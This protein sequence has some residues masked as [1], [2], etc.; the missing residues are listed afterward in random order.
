MKYGPG[1][2]LFGALLGSCV[3]VF[4]VRIIYPAGNTEIVAQAA[5]QEPVYGSMIQPEIVTNHPKC[6]VSD[7]YP[8]KILQW[9]D[10]IAHYADKHNINPDLIAAIIWQESGGKPQAY[11]KSGAVGLMQ[12][13]PRDGIAASFICANGPCFTNRP[14]IQELQDPEF[15]IKYGTRMLVG[16]I[17][18]HGNTRDALKSY[19]PGQVGYYY[20]D[21][22]LGIYKEYKQ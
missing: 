20:A 8:E 9:C 19:G 1:L 6:A 22:V 21:I 3:L 18:R 17:N 10:L 11:S 13:M 16:L 7:R 14:S 15:N 12:V 4:T 2:V 5:G